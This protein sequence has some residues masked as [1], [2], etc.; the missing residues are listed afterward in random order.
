VYRNVASQKQ[1]MFAVDIVTNAPKTGDAANITIYES[2]DD[3]AVTAL[4]DTSASELEATNAVGLYTV[5][6]TQAETNA[7][8]IVFSGKSSTSNVRIVPATVYTVPANFTNT[9]ID[10]NGR[11][12]VIKVAG[13]TQTAGDLFGQGSTTSTNV[14]TVSTN[15]N[16]TSTNVNTT[17]TNVNTVSTNLNAASTVVNTINTNVGTVSTNL[18][19][20]STNVNTVSTNL[21]TIH[22]KVNTINTNVIATPGLVWEELLANHTNTGTTGKQLGDLTTASP[23]AA[24]I[25]NTVWETLLSAH[26][27]S[28]T[29]GL[30]VNTINT[31]VTNTPGLV[32]EVALA[33]HTNVGTAGK[34]L[35][36]ITAANTTAIASAVWD[37][38]IT[39]IADDDDLRSSIGK[40]LRGVFER[41]FNKVTQTVTHQKMYKDDGSTLAVDM[42]VSDDGTTQTK[43]QSA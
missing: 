21:N 38:V 4:T 6:L 34:K 27:N 7:A 36:D 31:G 18:N 2:L 9:S 12:D 32:W 41:L 30:V 29:Y 39:E 19:T 13:T 10:S 11:V 40:M 37:A 15:L 14:N 35:G 42:G 26:T 1:V 8:K 25:A 28:G 23:S 16:T 43:G 5:D 17:S 24:T 22:G 20:T 3:G 33:S